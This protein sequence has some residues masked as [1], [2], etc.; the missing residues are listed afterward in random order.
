M[1][2]YVLSDDTTN[3]L[4]STE[5]SNHVLFGPKRIGQIMYFILPNNTAKRPNMQNTQN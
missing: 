5:Y 1:Q 3:K 2:H 4:R